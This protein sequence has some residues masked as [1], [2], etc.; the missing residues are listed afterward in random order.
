VVTRGPEETRALAASLAA[1]L[2]PGAVVALY[3]DL[4]AGKTCFVQGLAAAFGITAPV[5]SPT[6]N[7]V[8]EYPGDRRLV[9]FDLYRV[10]HPEEI[11]QLG[12]EEFLEEAASTVVVEWAERAGDLIPPG[13]WR[14]RIEHVDGEERRRVTIQPGDAG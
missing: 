12:W 4:G 6:Y 11:L 13:A 9:H 2:P 3:G 7:L 5:N 1:R 14:I 10:N 8:H